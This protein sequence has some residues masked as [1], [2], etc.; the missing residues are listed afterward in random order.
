MWDNLTELRQFNIGLSGSGSVDGPPVDPART[1]DINE[2]SYAAYGQLNYEF[3]LG[4]EASIDGAIGLRV[5]KTEEDIAGTLFG[6]TGGRS[7]STSRTNIRTGC[8]TRTCASASRRELQLR[9]AATQTRTRPTFQQLN[10]ALRPRRPPGAA[11]SASRAAS[12]RALAAIR[13]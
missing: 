11:R 9:L 8:P 12:A 2:K 10:P 1:F 7:R 3:E 13:S 6:P 5:V 4:G